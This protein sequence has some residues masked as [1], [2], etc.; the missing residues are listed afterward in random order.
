[1]KL[2]YFFYLVFG[3]FIDE[4][5]QDETGRYILVLYGDGGGSRGAGEG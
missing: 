4:R 2:A 5:A 1:V 3:R